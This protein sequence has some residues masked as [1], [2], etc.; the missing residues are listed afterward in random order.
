MRYIRFLK[1]PR[2][3]VEKDTSRKQIQCLITITSD[4]GDSFLPENV[5]LVAEVLTPESQGNDEEVKLWQT[6]Q[7]KGGMRTLSVVFPLP[8]S[9]IKTKLLVKVGLERDSAMDDYNKL[10]EHGSCGIVSA[11]SAEFDPSSSFPE[12][13]KL[14]QRRLI[15]DDPKHPIMI[16][17]ETGESIA[18]HLW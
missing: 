9:L 13:E 8:K 10:K 3:V 6:V 11:W 2:V 16:W 1:T 5:Q 12:A 4:L 7:W 18:R 15:S 14:V 17:E